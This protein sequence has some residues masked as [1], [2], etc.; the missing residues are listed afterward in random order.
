MVDVMKLADFYHCSINEAYYG[1]K[2]PLPSQRTVRAKVSA[3]IFA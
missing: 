1:V 2:N 3:K